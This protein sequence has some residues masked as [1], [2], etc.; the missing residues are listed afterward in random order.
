MR[1]APELRGCGRGL[2]RSYRGFS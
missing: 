2:R 1:V